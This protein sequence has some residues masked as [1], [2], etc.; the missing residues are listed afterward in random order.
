[1]K[2]QISP[3]SNDEK[4]IQE[5][6]TNGSQSLNYKAVLNLNGKKVQVLIKR[7]SYDRQSYAK[8]ELFD[9]TQWNYLASLA[10]DETSTQEIFYQTKADELRSEETEMIA[11][12]VVALLDLANEILF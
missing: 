6:L 12:D 1:M 3:N 11:E 10:W 2:T 9:G 7:D 8:I 4:L 5:T